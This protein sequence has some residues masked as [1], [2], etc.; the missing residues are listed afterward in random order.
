VTN[1]PVIPSSHELE[2]LPESL[3]RIIENSARQAGG[4]IKFQPPA[5][6]DIQ[7]NAKV[8]QSK[9]EL[10]ANGISFF[11][12]IPR[13]GTK[14][15]NK[16]LEQG[17]LF[18]DATSLALKTA[19]SL[20]SI[21]QFGNGESSLYN[22]VC[23]ED[24]MSV[25]A[26]D[27]AKEVAF[28]GVGS[29]VEP[30]AAGTR[31]GGDADQT[32]KARSATT[33]RVIA[34]GER[35]KGGSSLQSSPARGAGSSSS[36]DRADAGGG[37]GT[38]T[39]TG[40]LS[41]VR[42][43]LMHVPDEKWGI[44][45]QHFDEHGEVQDGDGLRSELKGVD[46]P[47]PL[48]KEEETYES[49]LDRMAGYH[50]L[51]SFYHD[52]FYAVTN[53]LPKSANVDH[54]YQRGHVSALA[55]D[56]S[57]GVDVMA[58]APHLDMKPKNRSLRFSAVINLTD[59]LCFLGYVINSCPNT[60]LMIEFE[61]KEFKTFRQ[62]FKKTNSVSDP[63]TTLAKFLGGNFEDSLCFAWRE[64]VGQNT[65]LQFKEM[66]SVYAGMEPLV[67]GLFDT[68]GVHWGAPYP[69]KS[70]DRRLKHFLE[71]HFRSSGSHCHPFF[72]GLV[73]HCPAIWL[74]LRGI[75]LIQGASLLL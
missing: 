45:F 68:D 38:A 16:A 56:A 13:Q 37:G 58:Q 63:G 34:R 46:W 35:T 28:G 23:V 26:S 4:S 33:G 44:I 69:L 74:A 22:R 53:T 62:R 61:E 21:I 43:Y 10:E 48:K 14:Q 59:F 41:V 39:K 30:E 25:L 2:P 20:R 73:L 47:M 5:S 42:A 3:V 15:W 52:L 24:S 75:D 54:H 8:L 19:E 72:L 64:Y 57:N 7:R 1:I 11:H 9:D 32:Q 67:V 60:K 40:I 55:C 12:E 49:F 50:Y 51:L 70:E 6:S 71:I 18:F 17:L 27:T 36:A 29:S 31:V 65:S 66:H